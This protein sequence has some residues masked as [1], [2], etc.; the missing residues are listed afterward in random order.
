M[1]RKGE[2]IYK[3][4]DG[5]WEGRYL[6]RP[7]AGTSRKYTSIY[8]QSYTEVKQKLLEA[9]TQETDQ[10]TGKTGASHLLK[11]ILHHWLASR[12]LCVK[13]STYVR[14]YSLVSKHIEPELR[15]YKVEQIKRP[16]I[17]KYIHDL[18]TNGRLDG[19]GGLSQKTAANIL[20]IIEEAL[21]YGV[22]TG[23]PVGC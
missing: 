13:Q 1:S 20:I 9:R 10:T 8:G 21:A 19:T 6:C 14:Y 15:F 7:G 17:E 4:K 23:A 18:L 5:R 12:Q 3:R 16:I 11:D 22:S 2:N